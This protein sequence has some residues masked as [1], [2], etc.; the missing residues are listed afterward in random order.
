METER[1]RLR[2]WQVS[3]FADFARFDT[4][5]DVM[6]A[7]G[8][9]PASNDMELQQDFRLALK[10]EGCYAIVLKETGRPIGQ[11]KFQRDIRRFHTNSVSVA[12]ELSTEFWGRGYMTEALSAMV[13]HAFEKTGVEVVTISH[14]T[15]NHRSKRVIEKCGFRY[16]GTLLHAF[17]RVDGAVFDD[18]TYSMLREEYLALKAERQ[19]QGELPAQL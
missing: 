12:Y 17:R 10:N 15:V 9:R 3:D 2:R 7:S 19:K 16:E 5:P 14:F 13:E 1:L 18:A 8:A 4:D 6:W 11:I